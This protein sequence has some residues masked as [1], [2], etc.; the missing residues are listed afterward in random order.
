MEGINKILF[1]TQWQ[2][3]DALVQTYTLP[4][5][6][7]VKKITRALCY[8]V[9]TGKGN[10]E[11]KI[12]EREGIRI[13]ELP[14]PTRGGRMQWFKNISILNNFVKKEQITLIHTWCTPAGAIGAILKMRNSK[15]KLVL[16]SVEPHA[17]AMVECNI[18][19]KGGIKFRGLFFLEKLQF[20]KAD[21]LIFAATEMDKYIKS[22]FGLT[23][24]GDVKPACVD[25]SLFSDKLLKSPELIRKLNLEGKVVCVYAGKF[26]G[27]YL[28]DETFQFV[29]QCEE[30]W[31]KDKFR[32]LALSNASDEYMNEKVAKFNIQ[33]ATVLKLFVPYKEVSE[34]MGLADFAFS[35]Y[36]PVPSKR[37][38]TPI[39]NGE[40]WA[41]GLPVV[42][43]PNIS[44]D[45]AIIEKHYAG[46]ILMG[47][48]QENYLQAI[49]QVDEIIL[50]KS[51]Q[52]IYKT[53][54]PLAEQYRNFN[55]AEKVYKK[56]YG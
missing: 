43:P 31:G 12:T 52:E 44:D 56:I 21:Y 53:I 25:L 40:Y 6:D 1:V 39:K 4:Y 27:F 51:R 34:Y 46:A 18:W 35:A 24:L 11:V 48:A 23:V 36:K 3:D 19:A 14:D 9:T 41:L 50:N 37:Y 33:P 7:I 15:V 38:G 2:Y 22:K 10:S 26:G 49:K 47:F 16:D 28:E 8:L 55:I 32:F 29:K 13:I 42:I 20:K 30:Y 54:R 17:E 5:V 45:S